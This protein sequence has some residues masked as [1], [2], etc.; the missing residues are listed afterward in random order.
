MKLFRVILPVTNIE[1]ATVFYKKLFDQEGKR[2]SLG[3]HYF[4]CE[5]TIIACYDPRADGDNF[6]PI[7]NPEHIYFSTTEL[8]EIYHRAQNIGCKEISSIKVQSWGERSFYMRDLYG[9]PLCFIDSITVFT[10]E[11]E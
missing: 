8:E 3:R 7:S 6:D 11:R 9:N 4:D 5:G 10:G 1:Q 2:V